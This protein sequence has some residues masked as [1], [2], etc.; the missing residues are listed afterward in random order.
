MAPGRQSNSEHAFGPGRVQARVPRPARSRWKLLGRD[1]FERRDPDS[2]TRTLVEDRLRK[3]V[4]ARFALTREMKDAGRGPA[5]IR[6]RPFCDP[7][8]G[9]RDVECRGRIAMLVADNPYDL[10]RLT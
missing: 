9:L 10:L 3:I 1:R 6:Y 8:D 4:P 5:I 7:Q 2:A